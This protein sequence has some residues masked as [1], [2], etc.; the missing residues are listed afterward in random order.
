MIQFMKTKTVFFNIISVKWWYERPRGLLLSKSLDKFPVCE[1][2]SVFPM[3]T[4]DLYHFQDLFYARTRKRPRILVNRSQM[5]I[6]P[7]NSN[8][9]LDTIM[10]LKKSS[11]FIN[12]SHSLPVF[13]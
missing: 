2:F 7:S 11:N 9:S 1:K 4:N 10:S 6:L 12:C 13:D 8:C 3:S 5:N